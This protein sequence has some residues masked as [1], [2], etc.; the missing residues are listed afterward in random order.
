M[1][2]AD[3][4]GFSTLLDD[5]PGVAQVGHVAGGG[6]HVEHAAG[7][8]ALAGSHHPQLVVHLLENLLEVGWDVALILGQVPLEQVG[9][10]LRA[11]L[12]HCRPA[13]SVQHCEDAGPVP[14]KVVK[15][16]MRVLHGLPD[17]K[18]LV[19]EVGVLPHGYGLGV[20]LPVHP[21][22]HK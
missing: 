8:A 2:G 10:G 14:R 5:C 17:R 9:Q 4:A 22:L 15:R 1:V 16:E 3:P 6:R 20:V 19:L 11:V 7:A 18:V 13:V 21:G 12:D